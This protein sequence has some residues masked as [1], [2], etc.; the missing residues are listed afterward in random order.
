MALLSEAKR[1]EYFKFL[2]LGEY[3]KANI[4]KF[5]KTAFP[6]LPKEWDGNFG[7]KTNNAL[8]HWRNVYKFTKNFRPE[9]FKCECGGKYC[10]GYPTWMKKVELQNLQSIRTHFGKPVKVTSGMRCSGYNKSLKG[11]IPKSKHLTGYAADI[12]IKGVTDTLAGR[13]S[14]IKYAKALPNH[15]YSYCNGYN[16]N[17]AR[18]S[19][20][21]MGS[22][23]HI[24]SN[25]PAPKPKKAAPVKLAATA[26]VVAPVATTN[27]AQKIV[28][29][30]AEYCWPY[31]TAKKKYA[32]S[33]GSAKSAYKKALKKHMGKEAKVSRSDCG[34]FVNTCVRA[35]GLGKLKA[36]PGKASQKYPK[37]PSTMHIVHKG[38]AIPSGLLQPGDIIRYRKSGSKQHVMMYFGNG[39]IAEANRKNCFPHISKDTKKYNKSNVRKSTIQV[40]RAK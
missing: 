6:N 5:Q 10:T 36:L 7:T 31:G 16:S 29:K 24:D 25:K 23:V 9:E 38:K 17:G 12:Y 11:S 14:L 40:I 18:I 19:A 37:L 20:S 27:A 4:K 8:R 2:G 34:Y 26:A 21:Y 32:Y 39:K 33:G 22:A 3:N 1:K 28:A 15:G 13:K 35:A 30:A